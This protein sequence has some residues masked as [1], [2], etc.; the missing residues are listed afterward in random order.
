MRAR[1]YTTT[2]THTHTHTHV[3]LSIYLSIYRLIYIE[4]IYI[5]RYRLVYIYRFIYI[6]RLVA[7]TN[8]PLVFYRAYEDTY[9]ILHIYEDTYSTLQYEDTYIAV[10]GHIY[11]STR[12]HIYQYEETYIEVWGHIY[13]SMRP[14]ATSVWERWCLQPSW[15]A[16]WGRARTHI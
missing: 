12:T 6:Y 8:M 15:R 5:D 3:Y 1:I 9:S 11:S 13:S 16:R 4:F 7:A 10:W 14:E 2:R